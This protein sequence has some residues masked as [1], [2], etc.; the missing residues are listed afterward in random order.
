MSITKIKEN[1]SVKS[2]IVKI[3]SKNR[4][5]IPHDFFKALNLKGEV[6]FILGE[7]EII[8]RPVRN[9]DK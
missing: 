6:E 7:G 4:V 8:I 5:T 1:G 9:R 2:K 3:T